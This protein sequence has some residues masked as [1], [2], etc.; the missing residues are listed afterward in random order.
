M[1]AQ[2]APQVE[3][4]EPEDSA[5]DDFSDLSYTEAFDKMVAMFREEYAFTKLQGHRLGR[6]GGDIPPAFCSRRRE[7]DVQA[8][9]RALRDFMLSI[10]DGHITAPL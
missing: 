6:D 4:I 8:Y 2:H 1:T 3:L 10:P 7:Q 9:R 5:L